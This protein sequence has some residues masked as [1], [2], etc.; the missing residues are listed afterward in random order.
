V[1]LYHGTDLQS[2]AAL[3]ADE[4]LDAG[5]ARD[6]HS[7]GELGF[8]LASD[9][10]DAEFFA[11]R[12]GEG[13]VITFELDASAVEQLLVGHAIYHPLPRGPASPYFSGDELFVPAK[14]FSQ[15]NELAEKGLIRVGS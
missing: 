10:G 4:P 12:Q 3:E 1:L 13:R 6:L 11:V 7:E 15:F 5:V 2:A 9:I 14:L 8:Y